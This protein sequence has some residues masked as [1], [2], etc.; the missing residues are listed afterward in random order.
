MNSSP[1]STHSRTLTGPDLKPSLVIPPKQNE[2][3]P[4]KKMKNL[5]LPPLHSNGFRDLQ[6]ESDSSSYDLPDSNISYGLNACAPKPDSHGNQ[7]VPEST[8]AP[9]ET[10]LLQSL[11]EDLKTAFLRR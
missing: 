10:V 11:K 3:R 8:S 7:G 4:Y 9:V 6:F 1:N 5:D 2:W